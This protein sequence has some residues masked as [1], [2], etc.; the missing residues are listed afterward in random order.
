M[1]MKQE[2]TQSFITT[3]AEKVAAFDASG[4]RTASAIIG[5][6]NAAREIGL[7]LNEWSQGQFTLTFHNAQSS[8]LNIPFDKLRSFVRIASR[9]PEPATTLDEAKAVIQLD[10]QTAGLITMPESTAPKASNIT[11]FVMFTNRIGQLREVITKLADVEDKEAVK[12]QLEPI[13]EYY[14]TL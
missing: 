8:Q 12:R 6:V 4:A 10:F 1:H 14:Q 5:H 2:L 3:I 13:V 11:P 7:L 9:L